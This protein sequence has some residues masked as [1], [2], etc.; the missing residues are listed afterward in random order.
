[1]PPSVRPAAAED[2]LAVAEVYL[3][4]FTAAM[5]SVQRAHPDDEVRT[6]VRDVLVRGGSVVVAEADGQVVGF[7]ALSDGWVEQLYVDPSHQG[8]GI[9]AQLLALAKDRQ[10]DGLQLWTFQV[11][12]QAQ[13]FY[14]Q[15]GF[16]VVERTDGSGNEEREP[17]VRYAWPG[18][19]DT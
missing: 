1:M 15:H 14:E 8:Q 5:P 9:G 6:W 13:R 7:V 12:E 17:D 2:A 10:P 19:T 16:V 3:R 11:N 18:T 4:S